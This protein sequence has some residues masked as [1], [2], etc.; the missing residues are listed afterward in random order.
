M[1][2]RYRDAIQEVALQWL[3]NSPYWTKNSEPGPLFIKRLVCPRCGNHKAW[4]VT[5]AP[6]FIKCTS[7]KCG[8]NTPLILLFP[9]LKEKVDTFYEACR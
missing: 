4:T 1:T 3:L 7:K 5:I 6:L 2:M 8:V 9:E